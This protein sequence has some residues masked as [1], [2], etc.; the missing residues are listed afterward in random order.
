MT[1]DLHRGSRFC[2][3]CG[4]PTFWKNQNDDVNQIATI[5]VKVKPPK[6]GSATLAGPASEA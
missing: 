4:N 1:P 2:Q 5:T 3:N 6:S